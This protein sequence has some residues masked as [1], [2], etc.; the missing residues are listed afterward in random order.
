MTFQ[1]RITWTSHLVRRFVFMIMLPLSGIAYTIASGGP[2]VHFIV[3]ILFAA[4]IGF[5]SNLALSECHGLI[6]ETYDTSDLQPGTNSRH[7]LQSMAPAQKRRRTTYSSYPRVSAGFFAAHS[8]GFLLAAAAVGVGGVLTRTVGYQKAT[9]ITAGILF[10]LTLLLTAVLW[11]FK[12]TQVI[13]NELFSQHFGS[14]DAN[15]GAEARRGSV[16]SVASDQSWRAVVI[17]N[18]SGKMRRMSM[19]ELGSLSR[20]TEI[21]RLNRMLS[22][23]ST[24]PLNPGWR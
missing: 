11:R 3:P 8:L 22:R 18:P 17:G 1:P 5:F 20:W 23:S 4:A 14:T 12:H 13:P 2:N 21:R 10:G 16:R 6:M 7:R 24:Q 15:A 19:L 9:G